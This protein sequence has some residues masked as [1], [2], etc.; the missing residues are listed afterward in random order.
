MP[1]FTL[2]R[3]SIPNNDTGIVIRVIPGLTNYQ[4]II[5]AAVDA[6]AAKGGGEVKLD[7]GTFPISAPIVMKDEVKLSGTGNGTVLFANANLNTWMITN[8][9][10][11]NVCYRIQLA[12]FKIDGNAAN[13]S[14][15]S[16]GDNAHGI[17]FF[18]KSFSGSG[19]LDH[20]HTLSNLTIENCRGSGVSVAGAGTVSG[21]SNFFNIREMKIQKVTVR[22]C[23]IS[24][25]RFSRLSDSKIDNCTSASNRRPG[26][27]LIGTGNL[28]FTNCKAFYN[29]S[30]D[31]GSGDIRLETANRT[32]FVGCEV[33]ESYGDGV[34]ASTNTEDVVF[35][36]CRFD[37][38]GTAPLALGGTRNSNNNLLRKSG[39]RAVNTSQIQVVGC[40]FTDFHAAASPGKDI[41]YAWQEWGITIDNC[42]DVFCIFQSF[43]QFLG[44]H[45]ILNVSDLVAN[46]IKIYSNGWDRTLFGIAPASA[47][48]TGSAGEVRLTNN[49]VHYCISTNTWLRGVLTTW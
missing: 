14:Q 23:R 4:P 42:T 47:T 43:Y 26:Y 16:T 41:N 29:C 7:S 8:D 1:I 17:Y 24:G 5:Q 6:Q 28:N 25:F 22:S 11:V 40:T 13:Q 34:L 12:D 39:I 49:F 35:V 38:N 27:H 37:A 48:A 32:T 19:S 33:Q 3:L 9:Q 36:G 20:Y 30:F 2:R 10:T 44:S 45:R 15:T 18:Q 31:S 46:R 21:L